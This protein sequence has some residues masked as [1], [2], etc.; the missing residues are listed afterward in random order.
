MQNPGRRNAYTFT[1]VSPHR[2]YSVG[3]PAR[4]LKHATALLRV[5]D[6]LPAGTYTVE[7]TFPTHR[8]YADLTVGKR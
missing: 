6:G 2:Q 5:T 4:T 7:R 3:L 1:L 8:R